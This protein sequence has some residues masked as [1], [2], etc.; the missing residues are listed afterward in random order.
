[1]SNLIIVLGLM[2][3]ACGISFIAGFAF[4]AHGFRN[5]WGQR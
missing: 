1:M 2:G 3:V 4:A 5:G